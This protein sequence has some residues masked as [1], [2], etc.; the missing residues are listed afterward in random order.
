MKHPRRVQMPKTTLPDGTRVP[1]PVGI[2]YVGDKYDIVYAQSATAL[3]QQRTL[4]GGQSKGKGML[5]VADPIFDE[6]DSRAR[7]FKLASK[8]RDTRRLKEMG[9]VVRHMG[10]A[11]RSRKGIRA[12]RLIADSGNVTFPRLDQTGLLAEKFRG[13]ADI[14][15]GAQASERRLMKTDLFRYKYII[16]AT[17]GI[18]DKNIPYLQEPTL[19]LSQFETDKEY[20]GF[21]TMREAMGLNLDADVV[22]LTACK[23]GLGRRGAGEGVMGLGRAFQIAGAKAVLVS[24]WSVAEDSTIILTEKFFHYLMKGYTKREALRMARRDVRRLGFE[25]P[26][27]WAPFILM[28]D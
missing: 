23:T 24:L 17:H 11:Q 1:T 16:F 22:A 12:D 25:H 26:F 4:R 18:L 14:L 13:K 20:D 8:R 7:G 15:I 9:A 28:G 19:V 21:L 6:S 3:S 5:I 10:V 2:T 27:F